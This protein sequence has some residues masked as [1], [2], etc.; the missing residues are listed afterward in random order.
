MGISLE[1]IGAVLS[2]LPDGRTPTR[3]DWEH[4]CACWH[5]DLTKRIKRLEAL[6][7]QLTDCIG[8]GCLSLDRCTLANPED[9][10]GELGAG[11]RRLVD[12]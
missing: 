8:C 5:A 12:D 9:I 3:E 11:A 4:A 1:T 10:L 6:R 7:D 2:L